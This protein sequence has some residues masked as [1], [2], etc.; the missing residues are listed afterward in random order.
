VCLEFHLERPARLVVPKNLAAAAHDV[1]TPVRRDR[2]WVTGLPMNGGRWRQ[3]AQRP[4]LASL[5]F[6][7]KPLLDVAPSRIDLP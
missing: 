2:R 1:A 5:F 7:T 4:L 3:L 6:V